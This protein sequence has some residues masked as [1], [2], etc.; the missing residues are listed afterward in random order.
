MSGGPGTRRVAVLYTS[1]VD[2]LT[3]IEG[4]MRVDMDLEVSAREVTEAL[5]AGGHDAR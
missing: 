5:A 2:T 4:K 1:V 3:G